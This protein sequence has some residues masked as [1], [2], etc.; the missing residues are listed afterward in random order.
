MT[1]CKPMSVPISMGTKILV[2]QCPTSSSNMEDMDFGHYANEFGS[3]MYAM[4][5]TRPGIS[6]S[7][8]T[9]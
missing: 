1:Y 7:S 5:H 9:L 3:L 8:G 4:V 6:P 2:E